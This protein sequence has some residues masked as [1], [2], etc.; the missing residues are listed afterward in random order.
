MNKKECDQWV[1]AFNIFAE[2]ENFFYFCVR[3]FAHIDVNIFVQLV[4]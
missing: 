3:H 2:G 4:Y 1:D